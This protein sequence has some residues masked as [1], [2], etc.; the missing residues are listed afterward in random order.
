MSDE[1]LVLDLEI[2]GLPKMSLNANSSWRARYGEARKWKNLV[3][4]YVVLG[5]RRPPEPLKKAKLIL[6]RY[7]FGRKPDHDNL[8]ASFKHVVDGLVEAGV[9]IDDSPDVIG[10]PIVRHES[11]GRK[12]GKIRIQVFALEDL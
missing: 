3:V 4:Q 12:Q 8:R 2:N 7:A 5:Q 1:R 9:L 11:I 6:T 10:E